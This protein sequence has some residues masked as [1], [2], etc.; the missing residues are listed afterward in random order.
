M[1]DDEWIEHCRTIAGQKGKRET[2]TGKIEKGKGRWEKG[3]ENELRNK[4]CSTVQAMSLS[5]AHPFQRTDPRDP[6]PLQSSGKHLGFNPS[7]HELWGRDGEGALHM[8]TWTLRL[9]N[10]YVPD[11][12]GSWQPS[13]PL[14]IKFKERIPGRTDPHVLSFE[15]LKMDSVIPGVLFRSRVALKQSAAKMSFPLS[16]LCSLTRPHKSFH[17]LP[18]PLSW[19]FSSRLVLPWQ[20]RRLFRPIS[21]PW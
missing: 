7:T 18:H 9:R 3:R 21:D 15:D 6:R 10:F 12:P 1:G 16:L 20:L 13:H 17:F 5:M 4:T 11:H 14:I 8:H 19:R 2:K